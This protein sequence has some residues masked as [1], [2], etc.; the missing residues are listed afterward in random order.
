MP[1]SNISVSPTAATG[2]AADTDYTITFSTAVK[3]AFGVPL[4]APV[5]VTFH[6]GA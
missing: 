1:K 3:D 2:W 5:T 6:T 4:P